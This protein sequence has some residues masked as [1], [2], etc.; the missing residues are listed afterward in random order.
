MG[1]QIELFEGYEFPTSNTQEVLLTLILQG[2]VS[3]F[4]FAYLA[5]FRTRISEL[6]NKHGL[7]LNRVIDHRNN[8]FGNSY[9]YAIHRLPPEEKDNAILLYKK[10]NKNYKTKNPS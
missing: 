1:E 8:R 6:N 3:L 10:L 5:S 9:Y 2:Y 7:K 4:D